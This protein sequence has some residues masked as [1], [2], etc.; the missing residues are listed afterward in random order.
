MKRDRPRIPQLGHF[1]GRGFI[2]PLTP[3][4]KRSSG[5]AS[6]GVLATRP[7]PRSRVIA[8]SH[9]IVPK[10]RSLCF[11]LVL[12]IMLICAASRSFG[13]W[14]TQTITLNPGWNAVFL[15][16]QP[17][18][19]DCDAVFNGVPVESVWFWNRRFSSVQYIQDPNKLVPGQPDWLTYLPAAH[20]ARATRNLYALQGASAYLIKL[21]A[22]ATQTV[23]TI[24]G[25]PLVRTPNWLSDSFNLVGFPIA[26]FGTPTFESFFSGSAAHAGQPMYLLNA[27][28]QW[29]LVSNPTTTTMQAGHAYWVFCKGASTFSGPVRLTLEQ[30]DGLIYDGVLTEQTLRIKNNST[31]VKSVTIQELGS[32]APPTTNFPVLAGPVPLSY[33]VIDAT[34]HL[35]GWVSLPT[36]LQ[37]VNMQPGEEWVLQLEVNRP[38]M[39]SFVPP[40]NA[41]G[42][43]YQSILQVADDNGVRT[44]IGVSSEGLTRYAT[45][46]ARH[47]RKA[48]STPDPRAGLWVGSATINGV[49]QPANISSPTNPFPVG[50]PLQFRLLV[51][52]D[53]S[54]NA[55][56]LQKV[57]EMFKP[58]TLVPDPS[59]PSNNIVNP[60]GHYVLVTDDT[61]ISNYTGA[62]LVDSTPVGRRLSSAVFGFRQPILMAGSGAFGAGNFS[63]QVNLDYDDPVNPFKHRYHPDH[64]NLD[65]Q[66]F[67]NK[68]PEGVESF[69]VNRQINLQ[70]TAQDPDNSTVA[71]WGDDQLGG[72]YRETI[73]GLHSQPLY[74]SG[75]FRLT[76]ASTIGILN[77]GL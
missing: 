52:V 35:F 37:K 26:P 55:R 73:T 53:D 72:N 7:T 42:V 74:L 67:Q 48:A 31:S 46:N 45:A 50:T 63:C 12:S 22:G 68:L 39:A 28:G 21:Q 13:Q 59:N 58:G 15:E 49:S 11:A 10:R 23:W 66:L 44:L 34:N 8:G 69:T 47:Q 18:N 36:Q 1:S 76:R 20:P 40:T 29:T 61:L 6:Q 77:D 3:H 64:D 24:Q 2:F 62:T 56:L 33:Y 27:S 70:F 32:L 17:A 9:A 41:P 4:I 38:Q 16:V 57:L 54:G 71:G 5:L 51:H 25:T 43:L 19:I 75:T 60:P 65:N 30:H 14:V